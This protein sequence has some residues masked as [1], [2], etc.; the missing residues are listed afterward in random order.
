MSCDFRFVILVFCMAASASRAEVRMIEAPVLKV[1]VRS[2][3]F[4]TEKMIETAE[5]RAVPGLVT[6]PADLVGKQSKGTIKAGVGITRAQ[7]REPYS[8]V[9]NKPVTVRYLQG[10]MSLT[11]QGRA[12]DNAAKGDLVRVRNTKSGEIL[13]GMVLSEQLVEVKGL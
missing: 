2:S 3:E 6:D 8:V 10:P 12:L 5:V 1:P 11:V 9:R 7:V 13:E 4:I